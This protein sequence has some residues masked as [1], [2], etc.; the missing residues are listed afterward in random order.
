MQRFK[1]TA[2]E[3][4]IAHRREAGPG[5]G[6]R[7][8]NERNRPMTRFKL[9]ALLSAT[10]AA[11]P[12][13]A[14][15]QT[16]AR[17]PAPTAAELARNYAFVGCAM[18][19]GSWAS[20]LLHVTPNSPDEQRFAAAGGRR[21]ANCVTQTQAPPQST[22]ALRGIIAELLLRRDFNLATGA[23]RSAPVARF[24]MPTVAAAQGLGT[25]EQ[26]SLVLVSIGECVAR[27]DRAGLGRLFATP[28][29]TPE[30]R[31]AFVAL[32]PSIGACVPQG[33]SLPIQ[34]R[35]MRGYLA[36]GAYRVLSAA[37]P[38]ARN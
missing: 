16:P 8:M 6:S 25:A 32:V 4:E 20:Q 1:L 23:R 34:P 29:G 2:A 17:P 15:A 33:S 27:A 21:S 18:R 12:A 36:E 11:I 38:A 35:S 19:G 26:A 31:A 28:A 10:L 5:L 24:A 3:V 13:V 14:Q 37:P 9:I 22:G 7:R 30:E